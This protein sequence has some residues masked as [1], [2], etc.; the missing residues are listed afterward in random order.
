MNWKLKAHALAVLSRIPG[1]RFWY[2]AARR[3]RGNN[4]CDADREIRKALELINLTREAGR[5]LQN[6]VV[7]EIGTGERPFVPFL[8]RLAGADRVV[9]LDI[10][11]WLNKRQLL[12]TYR[13]LRTRIP[14]IAHHLQL[15]LA[16]VET[17]FP[18][19]VDERGSV[20][21]FLQQFRIEYHCPAD[22]RHTGLAGQSLDVVVSSNVLE[23]LT[24]KAL[25]EAHS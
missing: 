14:S 19:D 3:V 11:R 17:R 22:A 7:L 6:C 5:C 9:T 8:L 20:E 4:P 12:E 25:V 10:T 13:E 15:D 21:S 23:H 24:P 18:T 16:E 2:Q 1:S